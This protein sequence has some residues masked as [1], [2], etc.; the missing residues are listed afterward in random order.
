M[1]YFEHINKIPAGEYG[2]LSKINEEL[3]ELYDAHSQNKRIF[4]AVE[5]A[6]LL[7]ALG[8]FSRSKLKTP[9]LLII[10]LAYIRIPYKLVRKLLCKRVKM[11]NADRLAPQW[12]VNNLGELGVYVNDRY[13]FLY[14]GENIEYNKDANDECKPI[15]YRPVGK[16]EF[17][18]TC[19]PPQWNG[20]LPYDIELHYDPPL[21]Y[22]KPEDY[23]WRELPLIE[24]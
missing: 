4:S 16:R 3:A 15:M 6:D 20:D 14:K 9:L 11:Q 23:A 5:S 21:S 17:G 18:E 7:I 22:G 19:R 8:S 13:F 2:E 1:K 12:I 24:E 10:L